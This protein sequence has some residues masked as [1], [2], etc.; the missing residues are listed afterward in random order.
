MQ[1]LYTTKNRRFY[2]I[3]TCCHA[4][5]CKIGAYYRIKQHDPATVFF[6]AK[7]YRFRSCDLNIRVNYSALAAV[8][9][10]TKVIVDSLEYKGNKSFLLTKP[11]LRKC[12]Q[13]HYLAK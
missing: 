12:Q 7:T 4:N 9:N 8:D 5:N 13:K 10:P 2:F 11:S 1:H 6:I 3:Q